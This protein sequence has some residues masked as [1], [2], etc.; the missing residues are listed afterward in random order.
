MKTYIVTYY[1]TNGEVHAVR[2]TNDF[3]TKEQ[4]IMDII[5]RLD[6]NDTNFVYDED[7]YE[8]IN[9]SQVC[10]FTIDEV[11]ENE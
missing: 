10:R 8:F 11:E 3:V 9:F 6:K 4:F 2:Y 5:E 7:Y 1:F